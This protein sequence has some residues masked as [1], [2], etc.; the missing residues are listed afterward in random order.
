MSES[1]FVSQVPTVE[2]LHL[3]KVLGCFATGV[4]VVTTCGKSSKPAGVTISSFNSLSLEPP[5]IL[6]SLSLNAPS[7]AA[8]R[9]NEF[10]A[11][12]ILAESQLEIC[13][14][15]ARPSADKFANIDHC[16]GILGIPLITGAAAHLECRTYARYPGGDHEIYVGKV[17]AIKHSEQE[18]LLFH[19]GAFRSFRPQNA[20]NQC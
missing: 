3:R 9:T 7:L 17:V 10:F 15:F 19:R 18:P 12:N 20:E 8:F 6:W 1:A 11:V 4:A 5:L 16:P 14:N 13:T 2:P